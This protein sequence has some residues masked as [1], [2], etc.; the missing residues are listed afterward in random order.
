MLIQNAPNV[1]SAPLVASASQAAKPASDSAPVAVAASPPETDI[2][3]DVKVEASRAGLQQ[4]VESKSPSRPS[5]EQLKNVVDSINKALKQANRNLEFSVDKDTNKQVVKLVD[6]ETGDVIRQ[7]P[8][9]EMLA[10]S[11]AIGKAQEE[12]LVMLETGG[13]RGQAQQG[14]LLKQE[15]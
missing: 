10:I 9:D 7:F 13:A 3:S 14:L 2:K 6:S 1:A 4:A 8:S 15:A 12:M 5:A 11:R